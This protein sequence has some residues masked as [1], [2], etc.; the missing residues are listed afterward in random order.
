MIRQTVFPFKLQRSD[1]TLTAHGGLALLA[2]Y[3]HSLG[4]RTLADRHL[5]SPREK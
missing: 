1:E 4:L 2:E 3:N 5:P